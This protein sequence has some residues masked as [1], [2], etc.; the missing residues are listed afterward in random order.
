MQVYGEPEHSEWLALLS[1]AS[2]DTSTRLRRLAQRLPAAPLH[3]PLAP[4]PAREVLEALARRFPNHQQALSAVRDQ[5]ALCRVAGCGMRLQPMLLLGGPGTGKTMF[6][7]D[8]GKALG[9]PVHLVAMAHSSAGFVLSGLDAGWS[10]GRPGLPF[11]LLVFG[12]SA[13]VVIVL[14]E[15]DKASTDERHSPLGPLYSLLEP[16]TAR[17][18]V[19]EFAGLPI[20]TRS[21]I[22]IATANSLETIPKPLLSRFLVVK[23]ED[24]TREQM[25]ALLA[26]VWEELL[27]SE[28]WWGGCFERTLPQGT[29]TALAEMASLRDASSLLRRGAARAALEGRREVLPGDLPAVEDSVRTV[30]RPIGFIHD[31]A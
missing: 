3:K 9:A 2:D 11:Q 20:D 25:P 13:T 15:V 19:D 31:P 1:S 16:S 12:R 22:W 4:P 8:T 27:A 10:T 6:A 5:A 23:A 24:P 7:R 17:A 28:P 30:S 26:S 29:M 14:D 18:F 21:I